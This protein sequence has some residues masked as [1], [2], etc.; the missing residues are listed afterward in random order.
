MPISNSIRLTLNIKDKNIHFNKNFVRD[1]LI[2]GV[3][4]LV[5]YGTLTSYSPHHC[6]ICGS[7]N[8]NYTII[9]NGSK[10]VNV[11]LPRVSNRATLLKLKKQR[12]LC[13]S[14]NHTFSPHSDIVKFNHSISN[15]T[16]L[17]SILDM[18]KKISIKDIAERHD[19]SHT[20]LNNWLHT[21][22]DQFTIPKHTLP[23][24]L[25]FDEFKS[26]S[27]IAAKMSFIVTDASNGNVIDIVSNRQ[28]TFLRSYFNTYSPKALKG[29]KT[30][31]I[32]MYSPYIEVIKACFPNALI[33]TDRF[34]VIQLLSRSLNSTRTSV[35]KENPKHYRK[36]K[37]YWKLLL[38]N[39]SDLN[40]TNYR[41]FHCFHHLMTEQ[42]VVDEL[43]KIDTQLKDIYWFYQ[44]YLSN[45]KNK[46][47]KACKELTENVNPN[48][49]DTMKRSIRSLKK[50]ETSIENALK[51]TYSN[52]VIEGTNNLIKVI[53]RIAFG[54]RSFD[55]FRSRILLIT[56]TQV[57]ITNT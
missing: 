6:P 56:N 29:V 30:V 26:V 48:I 9:K 34:H 57:K 31:C 21:L 38:K 22:R 49:S 8:D 25:C 44:E 20:S 14:C 39:Q 47:F 28:L 19:I 24:H 1:E 3:Q 40:N 12:F 33:I 16:F 54:Y 45:F 53:K 5:F 43:L 17:S 2:K 15:N 32:D 36:L 52:G 50:H 41:Y 37:R 10:I 18:K 51:F 46:N 11:R 42:L 55:N 27:S 35:M 13:R 7:I 23:E 4:T